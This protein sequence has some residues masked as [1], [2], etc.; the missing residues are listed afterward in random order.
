[1]STKSRRSRD[2]KG[3]RLRAIYDR[4]A[5]EREQFGMDVKPFH[6]NDVYEF[7]IKRGL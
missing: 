2:T 3:A 6:L 5:A 4:W 7:A 1:M